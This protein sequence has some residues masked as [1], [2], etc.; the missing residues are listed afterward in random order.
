MITKGKSF[1]AQRYL[2]LK[3]PVVGARID[4]IMLSFL[5]PS[6]VGISEYEN[7]WIEYSLERK[8]VKEANPEISQSPGML[9]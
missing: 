2:A 9:L 4:N 3:L 5:L 7:H 8:Q 1:H 6:G